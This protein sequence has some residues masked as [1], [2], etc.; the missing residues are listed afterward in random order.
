MDESAFYPLPGVVRTWAPRGETPVLRHKLTRDPLSV[1][2]A[3]TPE[4]GLFLQTREEPF[5]GAGVIAFLDGLQQQIAGELLIVWDGATIHRSRLLRQYLADGA[6][7][8]LHLE[9][10]PG[11]APEL[12]PAE[13]VW[14]HLKHVELGNL[15]CR[16]LAHLR[17]ELAAAQ[18]RLRRKPE[19]IRACFQQVGY[20]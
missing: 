16:D 4:G 14:H 10:L 15:C 18:G 2:S 5:D 17:E 13:G 6:A 20:L 12:N 1:I 8:R 7:A 3:V 9:R 19:I 11:Y